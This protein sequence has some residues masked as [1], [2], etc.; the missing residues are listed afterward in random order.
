MNILYLPIWFFRAKLL[1]K[2]AP[3]QTVLSI[4]DYC[5]LKCRHC[6]PATHSCTRMK[7]FQQI[8][9]ELRYAYDLGSRFLDLEG[10]EPVLWRDG[11]LAL[12]DIIRLAKNIGFATVTVTTNAQQPFSGVEADSIWV[13]LDGIGRYHDAIRGEGAF[14]RL[15]ANTADCGHPSL[16]ANM[17]INPVNRESVGETAAWVRDNPAF[18][19]ISFNFH[20]PWPDAED[21]TLPPNERVKVID[22]I[23][24]LKKRGHPIMNSYSGLKLMRRSGF[25]KYCWV[26]N[27]ILTDGSRHAS[28]PGAEIGLCNRCGFCMA[29]EMSA[30]MSLRPDTVLSGLSLRMGIRV[31]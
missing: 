18:R 1:G 22:E 3:L 8:Q 23:L 14:A 25:K 15:K 28:C 30:V 16:S 17:V 24:E 11:N 4:T 29:S 13:S 2:R 5:S 27:F 26:T 19:S 12:N 9:D 21:M 31:N 7:P 6:A 20:T 10:G